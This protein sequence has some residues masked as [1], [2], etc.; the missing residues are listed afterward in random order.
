MVERNSSEPIVSFVLHLSAYQDLYG[1]AV[2]R[3]PGSVTDLR[4]GFSKVGCPLRNLV[5]GED[6]QLERLWPS[7][8]ALLRPMLDPHQRGG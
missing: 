5:A 3:L 2:Q 1:G 7:L 8:H 6:H 4:P